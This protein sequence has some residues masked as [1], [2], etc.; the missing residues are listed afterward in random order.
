MPSNNDIDHKITLI[1]SKSI[2]DV[3]FDE[4]FPHFDRFYL[5]N[6]NKF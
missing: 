5:Y 1:L 2:V 3:I 4:R 6:P